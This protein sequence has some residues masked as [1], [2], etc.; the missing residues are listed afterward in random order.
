MYRESERERERE[1]ERKKERYTESE[2]EEKP[3]VYFDSF[4]FRFLKK[5]K[6]PSIIL[7]IF[8]QKPF[9]QCLFRGCGRGSEG[10]ESRRGCSQYQ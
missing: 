3:I 4:Q 7:K 5:N 2:T 6:P 9:S 8:Q 10:K 1:R